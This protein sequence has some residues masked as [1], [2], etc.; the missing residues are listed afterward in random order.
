M[1]GNRSLISNLLPPIIPHNI[2]VANVSKAQVTGVGQSS[3]LS[4]LSLNHV[5]F[6]YRSPFNLI[7]IAKRKEHGKPALMPTDAVRKR[8]RKTSAN[9]IMEHR[10]ASDKP[11]R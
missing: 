4:S 11:V 3:P 6:V 10:F 9:P 5:L 7:S 1:A 8:E 2:A